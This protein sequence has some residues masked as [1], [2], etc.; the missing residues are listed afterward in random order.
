MRRFSNPLIFLLL[1]VSLWGVACE[2]AA[3]FNYAVVYPGDANQNGRADHWDVLRI[4]RY[5]GDSLN[6]RPNAN[7]QWVPNPYPFVFSSLPQ[8]DRIH[9]DC[10]GDGMIGQLDL[11]TVQTHYRLSHSG[12]AVVVNGTE[13]FTGNP[14]SLNVRVLDGTTVTYPDTL[15]FPDTIDI[16]VFLDFPD[17]LYGIAFTVEIDTALT[18]SPVAFVADTSFI[19]FLSGGSLS[20]SDY[21]VFADSLP[22]SFGKVQ[23]GLRDISIAIAAHDQ[24]NKLAAGR[25]GC[26]IIDIEDISKVAALTTVSF[27]F[28]EIRAVRA[29]GSPVFIAP[30]NETITIVH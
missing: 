17:T 13:N 8:I 2:N 26:I 15:F 20:P 27:S 7:P 25:L 1:A 22:V 28:T 3:V 14:L 4:A 11:E 6:P 24:Q 29:D 5:W 21:L 9:A 10:N 23:A 18:V 12:P 19:T 30:V 16:E